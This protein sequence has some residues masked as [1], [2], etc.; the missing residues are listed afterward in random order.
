MKAINKKRNKNLANLLEYLADPKESKILSFSNNKI[1]K[2]GQ[3]RKT[4]NLDETIHLLM[5][6]V[7]NEMEIKTPRQPAISS[8]SKRGSSGYNPTAMLNNLKQ[9]IEKFNDAKYLP[10]KKQALADIANNFYDIMSNGTD[11][12]NKT[13]VD[14]L[15]NLE[16]PDKNFYE[17]FNETVKKYGDKKQKEIVA[18]MSQYIERVI[19]KKYI[20]PI[21]LSI[22]FQNQIDTLQDTLEKYR[23]PYLNKHQSDSFRK[24][25]N[26]L[27]LINKPGDT[28]DT[29]KEEFIKIL[30]KIKAL[31]PKKSPQKSQEPYAV[32]Q[33]VPQTPPGILG[34]IGS[35]ISGALSRFKGMFTEYKDIPDEV[36]LEIFNRAN[37]NEQMLIEILGYENYSLKDLME[38]GND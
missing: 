16:E 18:R 25:L 7:L 21:Q 2:R 28:E 22:E 5:E 33:N 14:Y 9:G 24:Q 31:Q 13:I 26:N 12:Q 38:K 1:N 30:N 17:N 35:G 27:R 37:I 32:T 4:K 10:L 29:K 36:L 3:K 15:K 23:V 11:E 6:E 20:E 34:K 8:N 19:E